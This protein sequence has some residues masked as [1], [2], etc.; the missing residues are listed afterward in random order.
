[1]IWR[2]WVKVKFFR[3][4]E[5]LIRPFVIAAFLL[6]RRAKRAKR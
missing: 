4:I 6:V 5:P 1:M 2:L 3:A